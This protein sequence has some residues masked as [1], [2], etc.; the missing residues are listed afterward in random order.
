[1]AAIRTRQEELL[2]E[3]LPLGERLYADKP[4]A[5]RRRIKAYWKTSRK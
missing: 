4:K 1:M 5:Y 2:S 3:A